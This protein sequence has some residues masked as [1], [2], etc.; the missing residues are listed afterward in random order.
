MVDDG[1]EMAL[2]V[3]IDRYGEG[4]VSLDEL[5]Q[6]AKTAG[7]VVIGRVM[8]GRKAPD[9]ATYIGRGKVEELALLS[10]AN[11][12]NLVI[13]D[14]E[15]TASQIRNLENVVGTKIIDRTALILDIFAGR[16]ISREGKLQVELAQLKYRLPRLT[17]LGTQLSRLGGGIGTRGPGEQKLETDRRHIYRRIGEIERDLEKV[18]NRR[19][20]LGI[21]GRRT[22]FRW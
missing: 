13:V 10:R 17:G 11:N 18:K 7:A 4:T 12:A 9:P 14:D 21:G 22:V 2:L 3:G 8:Q 6:L 5:E 20:A 1:Q 19:Q 15:L 16:A